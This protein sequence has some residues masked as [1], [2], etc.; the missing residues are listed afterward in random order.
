MTE[1][2]GI[3]NYILQAVIFVVCKHARKFFWLKSFVAQ[4]LLEILCKYCGSSA[5]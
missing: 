4:Q 2:E 5:M 3:T 1:D